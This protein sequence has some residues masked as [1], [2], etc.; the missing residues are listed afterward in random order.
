MCQYC[1]QTGL[2]S[3]FW[4]AVAVKIW[5]WLCRCVNRLRQGGEDRVNDSVKK[6]EK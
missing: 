5:Q 4:G 1:G 3:L 2:C 6:E